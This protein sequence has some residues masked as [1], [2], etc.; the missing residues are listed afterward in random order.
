MKSDTGRIFVDEVLETLSCLCE[1]L[2]K[3]G[4]ELILGIFEERWSGASVQG[5]SAARTMD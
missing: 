5:Q 3:L 1:G 4:G 2:A